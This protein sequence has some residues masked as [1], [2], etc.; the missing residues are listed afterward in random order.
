MSN[1]ISR[2]VKYGNE[3]GIVETYKYFPATYDKNHMPK[4]LNIYKNSEVKV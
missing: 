4:Y 3:V 2:N 1:Y